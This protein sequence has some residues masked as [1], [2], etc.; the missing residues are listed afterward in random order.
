MA[1]SPI[2]VPKRKPIEPPKQE[3]VDPLRRLCGLSTPTL[4]AAVSTLLIAWSEWARRWLLSGAAVLSYCVLLGASKGHRILPFINLYA[5][6]VTI[7][8]V[9]A[10]AAT[11]WLLYGAF[12]AFYY[13]AIFLTCLFQF[14]PVADF[15]RARLRSLLKPLHFVQDKIAFFNI[16]AL[17]IDTDVDGLKVVRGI[18][19]SFSTLTI[20]AYGIE[21]G[22]KSSD[23]M[24]IAI[25][26]EKLAIAL[27]RWIDIGDIYGNLKGGE[28][29]MTFHKLDKSRDAD[30]DAGMFIETRKAKMTEEMTDGSTMKDSSVK[31][32][33][34]AL[35]QLSPDDEWADKRYHRILDWIHET[36]AI[37]QGWRISQAT[38]E[39]LTTGSVCGRRH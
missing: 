37:C 10:I 29:E 11:S 35:S 24:E 14:S 15:V 6:L 36:S 17:E 13:Q 22:I 4:F 16:P 32:G 30:G 3:K 26:T 33:F 7:N 27:F 21:V 20:V 39:R 28:F 19:I 5:L 2:I 34:E 25:Q 38:E 8:L 31:A 23:D 12:V 9:Y 1:S 18:T